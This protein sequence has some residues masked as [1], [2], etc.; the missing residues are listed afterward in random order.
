MFNKGRRELLWDLMVGGA[1]GLY[2]TIFLNRA[3]RGGGPVDLG[4]ALFVTTLAVLFLLR[5]PVRRPGAFWESLLAVADTFL[6]PSMVRPAAGGWHWLGESIQLVSVAGMMA[7]AISL[8][9]SFG[10]SPADRGLRTT[11]LYRWV[12][13][14]L[15]AMELW[16]YVGY[17]VANPSWRNLIVLGGSAAIQIIRIARE[18][19]IL[20]GYASYVQQ[21]RWRLIPLAW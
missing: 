18:E 7:A 16:F 1:W 19:R 21:V 15:Y 17:V 6:P 20:E 8:G 9:R 5:R 11:G 4:V 10:I 14:P 2:A 13:H 12:R 3:L